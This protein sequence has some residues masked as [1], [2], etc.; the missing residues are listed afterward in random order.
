MKK[1]PLFIALSNQKG[2]VGK[3]TFTV[4]LASYYHY[5]KGKN[6]LVVDCD[7][8]QH[9]VNAMRE[10]DV[11]NVAKNKRLQ[12]LLVEQFGDTGRKAYNV[13][14]STPENAKETA[15]K[16]IDRSE[17]SYDLALFDLPGTVNTTGVFQTIINMDYVFTPIVQERMSMQSSMNF[18]LTIREFLLHHKEAPLR[19]I[20]MFWNRMDKRVSK[21][22]YNAYS[23]I[24]RSLQLRVL[25][26]TIPSAERYNKDAGVNGQ[27]FR[28]TLFPPS[29]ASLKGSDL[30]LLAAE[31]EKILKF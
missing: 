20:H 22:M 23:E 21:D 13:L 26:T 11:K 7:Y 18:V 30:D 25:E 31:I 16:F 5:L 28:S 19:D 6:V 4:L 24:F 3:S 15:C 10:W 17:V 27:I 12:D 8:P 2:G 29:T 9:S 14:I 1:E